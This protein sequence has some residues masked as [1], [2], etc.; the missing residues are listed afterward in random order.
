MT[1]AKPAPE[2]T[3]GEFINDIA[4]LD[5]VAFATLERLAFEHG[6]YYDS[7]LAIEPGRGCFFSPQ[8]RGAVSFARLGK[9]VKAIGGLLCPPEHRDE[10]L[11]QFMAHIRAIR[12]HVAFYNIA[13]DETHL[14]RQRGFQVAKWCDDATIDL[15]PRTWTGGAFEWIRRQTNYCTRH[16]I[17]FAEV[18]ADAFPRDRR[19]SLL[20]EAVALDTA[21][22]S[23]K[24]QRR[25]TRVLVG[26]FD[27]AHLHRRRLF[28]A[29]AEEGQGR[30]EGFIVCNPGQCG[31]F[32]SV[33]IYRHRPD[34]VRGVVPFLIHKALLQL[35]T[36]GAVTAS[37]CPVLCNLTTRLS[38]PIAWLGNA[39]LWLFSILIDIKGIYHFKSRFRPDFVSLSF[40]SYPRVTPGSFLAFIRLWG[41]ADISITKTCRIL[42]KRWRLRERRAHLA[43]SEDHPP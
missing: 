2:S 12:L 32:W 9:Y 25:P 39:A 14:F 21:L 33:E 42:L 8:R 4:Q 6:R 37:L 40:C 23:T 43:D 24:P 34:A 19:L 20:D 30:L 35:R 41:I 31:K 17:A 10:L 29:L 7:Y 1:S 18:T 3:A 13:D 15:A 38:P 11:D 5:P 26:T 22:L 36:E 16:G 28:V 27:P